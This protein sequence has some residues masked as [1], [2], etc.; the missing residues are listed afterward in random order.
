MKAK[1]LLSDKSRWTQGALARD[2]VGRE[3]TPESPDAES[4]CIV[5]ALCRVYLDDAAINEAIDSVNLVITPMSGYGD[6]IEEWNDDPD[7]TFA[8]VRLVLEIADV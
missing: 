5:G 1:D 4:F 7:R 3:C 2:R 8:E 6:E